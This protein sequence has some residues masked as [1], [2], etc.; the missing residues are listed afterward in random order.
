MCQY[1]HMV[2]EPIL[3]NALQFP[4]LILLIMFKIHKL[5][6]DLQFKH[7]KLKLYFI[8]KHVPALL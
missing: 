2:I 5:L 3:Y 7:F 4:I 6:F 1:S 8:C